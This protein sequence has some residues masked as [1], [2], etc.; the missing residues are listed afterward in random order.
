VSGFCQKTGRILTRT[1]R[2]L[3]KICQNFLSNFCHEFFCQNRHKSSVDFFATMSKK[4]QPN[5]E[6][7]GK[8]SHKK[9]HKKYWRVFCIPRPDAT[10]SHL[11]RRQNNK[12]VLTCSRSQYFSSVPVR[13][14]SIRV[15]SPCIRIRRLLRRCRSACPSRNHHSSRS[16]SRGSTPRLWVREREP[17]LRHRGSSQ[18]CYFGKRDRRLG[19]QPRSRILPQSFRAI[20]IRHRSL[21]HCHRPIPL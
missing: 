20:Q 12:N 14:G 1:D 16:Q 21:L 15:Q 17:Q 8:K 3:L 7:L 13:R 5:A 18:M 4:G 9:S 11:V 10:K 19:Q 6:K 2:I